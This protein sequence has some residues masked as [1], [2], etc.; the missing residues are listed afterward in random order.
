MSNIIKDLDSHILNSLNC[1]DEDFFLKTLSSLIGDYFEV[2]EVESNSRDFLFNDNNPKDIKRFIAVCFIRIL[3]VS[4]D[5]QLKNLMF[6]VS[7]LFHNALPDLCKTL[8]ISHKTETYKLED[9]IVDFISKREKEFKDILNFEGGVS[10]INNFQQTYRQSFNNSNNK[11][12]LSPFLEDVITRQKL[13]KI[14]LEIT[15]YFA[16]GAEKK[17]SF[18]QKVKG[19]LQDFITEAEEIGTLYALHFVRNPFNKILSA[20]IEDFESSPF[21]LPATLTIQKSEKKYPFYLGARNDI[22]LHLLKEGSG[23]VFKTGVKVIDYVA[24]DIVFNKKEYFIG[25]IKSQLT[26]VTFDY[27]VL[28][29]SDSILIELE[30]TWNTVDGVINCQNEVLELIGQEKNI[31]WNLAK[32]LQPYDLEPV[33]NENKLIGRENILSRLKSMAGDKIGSSYIYGQRRVGKTSIV[34]TLLNSISSDSL[35]VIYIEAGDWNDAQNPFKSMDTLGK[36]ICKKIQSSRKKFKQIPLPEFSGSFNNITEFLDQVNEID[37]SFRV[38]IILDEFDRI[39]REL[40]ERGEIG[41][42]FVLTI[43]SISN[44]SQFGFILVGGEKMEFILSQW[45]EFNKFK[46]VRVDYFSKEEDWKDF[47]QLVK[48]PVSGILEITDKAIEYIFNKTSGNP[49]FTKIICIELYNLMMTNRD[50]HVTTVEANNA[51]KIARNNTNIGA[52]DFSHFWEDGIKGRVEK[53]EETSIKRRKILII[54]SNLLKN[55]KLTTKSNIVD[56]ALEYDLDKEEVERYLQE[57]EQRKILQYSGNRYEFYV[58]F[59]EEWLLDGGIDKIISSFEEEERLYLNKK[60]DEELSVKF[61]EIND[62]TKHWKLY[63][64]EQITAN[65]VRSWLDQ[66]VDISDQRIIFKILQ[67]LKF[68]SEF[69][70]RE[71]LEMLFKLV[72]RQ[73]TNSGKAKTIFEGKRKRDDI[74]VTYLDDN[75]AK[76]GSYY[77]KIFVDENNLYK[78]NSCVPNLIEKRIKEMRNLNCLLIVDDFLG[79]GSTMIDNINKYED[80]LLLA[81]KEKGLELIFGLITGFQAAKDKVEKHLQNLNIT[82]N[83][84]IIDP[85]D[86]GNMCFSNS[87]DIFK[88]SIERNIAQSI[89]YR[90]GITIDKKQPLGY[91]DS[92]TAIVFPINCPNNTLPILWKRT[93]DW[94][95]LFER[96]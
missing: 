87:S 17:Y 93:E 12:I 2:K 44:R 69:E 29:D 71:K 14:F 6:L 1:I 37:E 72:K 34:K 19:D 8:N 45:Q 47:T 81:S 21:N 9:I 10:L 53:E 49:Y 40:F 63:K 82:A 15:E 33:D 7:K 70:V 59:F 50:V 13:D 38:L 94:K 83:V 42:S 79:S 27:E 67:N 26:S 56:N 75:P 20:I 4:G 24:S 95:P 39:S 80:E 73:I 30:L 77:T 31:D 22:N 61:Q 57:F 54:I 48:K 92:Q 25:D 23:Y 89:C 85:L 43:R 11:L 68:Y 3:G 58:N 74:L 41:K 64:G 46:P 51:S 60:K 35:F 76:G 55:E 88:S 86:D 18:Y 91:S 65:D 96:K 5:K 90:M 32:F 36:K 16:S 62:V 52:T 66:F 78:E 84:Y 28:K